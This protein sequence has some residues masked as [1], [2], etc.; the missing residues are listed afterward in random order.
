[1]LRPV[2][3][4]PRKVILE[5][6]RGEN[7]GD[8]FELPPKGYRAVGRAGGPDQ[9]AQLTQE[10]DQPLDTED[11]QRVEAHLARRA[12]PK[13]PAVAGS[14]LDHFER[15]PDILLNDA[16]V[17]RT[18]AMFFFDDTGISLVD[19][20]STNGTRVNGERVTDADLAEGDIVHVGRARLV[21]RFE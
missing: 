7:A 13:A 9:T 4:K 18:H 8:R 20:M 14:R 3:K 11:L 5:V 21:V 6:D 17:S 15:E 12:Q 16:D 19:L 10:G 1:M 2:I